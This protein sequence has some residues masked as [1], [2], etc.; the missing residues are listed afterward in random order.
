[1]TLAAEGHLLIEGNLHVTIY[2]LG[3]EKDFYSY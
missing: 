1:M 2:T 3:K